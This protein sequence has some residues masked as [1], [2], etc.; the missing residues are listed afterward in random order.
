M[1]W[2]DS[3]KEIYAFDKKTDMIKAYRNYTI[4]LLHRMHISSINGK[5]LKRTS[6]SPLQAHARLAIRLATG[7]S[8]PEIRASTTYIKLRSN[9]ENLVNSDLPGTDAQARTFAALMKYIEEAHRILVDGGELPMKLTSPNDAPY[10]FYSLNCAKKHPVASSFSPT[11]MLIHSPT[12]PSWQEMLNHFNASSDSNTLRNERNT[13]DL[14]RKR[15]HYNNNNSRTPLRRQIGNHAITA[16]LM[17]FIAATSCN[18]SVATHLISDTLEV[19]PS[20]QGNRFSGTKGRANGKEVYP[21]FGAQFAPFFKKLLELRLWVLNGKDSDLIFPIATKDNE[22][23]R[24][25]NHTIWSLKLHLA[26]VLPKTTWV[27]ASQWRK[28]VSYQYIKLSDGDLA[29]TAEKLNNNVSTIKKN[30]GRPALEDFADEMT[31]FFESVHQAAIDRTRLMKNIP[32]K[33][34][35][36]RNNEKNTSIGSC[37]NTDKASPRR[38]EGFSEGSPTPSCRDPE[39]CLFCTFYAVHADHEDIRRLLSL[40]FLIESSKTGIPYEQ[41]DNKFSPIL[42]RI[43][44]V[45]SAITE[46]GKASDRLI[47]EIREEVKLGALDPFWAIHVDALIIAGVIA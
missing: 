20:T 4:H 15:F 43:N 14:S 32:V 34:I 24:V 12:F 16:G 30:Y 42:H 18:L 3:E 35:D 1:E 19:V 13:Y 28:N 10:Y 44:E 11:S 5:P 36:E 21:E 41:W 23:T 39:S 38:A 37:E 7:L 45:L 17:A 46:N 27:T 22:V 33:L 8:E 25:F 6:A 9:G 2:I 47:H 29:L 40:Y 31:A 26:K